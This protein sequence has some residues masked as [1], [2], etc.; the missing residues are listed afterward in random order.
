MH[1]LCRCTTMVTEGGKMG[2]KIIW[3]KVVPKN[4]QSL[5][6]NANLTKNMT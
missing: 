1:Q 6:I 5:Q 3:K 2:P 4:L